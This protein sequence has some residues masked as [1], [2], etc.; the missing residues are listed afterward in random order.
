M[1]DQTTPPQPTERDL[2]NAAAREA[3][4]ARQEAEYR[5]VMAW[6]DRIMGPGWYPVAR[7]FLL[8]K[9]EEERCRHSGER[10]KAAATVYTVTNGASK[11][12]F[13]LR[14]GQPVE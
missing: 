8:E 1:S 12:H 10:P 2:A 6:A 14:D 11:R 5:Q 4:A 13:T 9:E 7:H 3:I